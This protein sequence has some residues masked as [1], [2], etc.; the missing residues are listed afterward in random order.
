[1][2]RTHEECESGFPLSTR[3]SYTFGCQAA[4]A[5]KDVSSG[6]YDPKKA[7]YNPGFNTINGHK[8]CPGTQNGSRDKLSILPLCITKISPLGHMLVD[9][10]ATET[11]L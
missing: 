3:T 2:P 11:P 7:T 4:R 9:Q 10:P 1:M 8:F 5:G 6:S